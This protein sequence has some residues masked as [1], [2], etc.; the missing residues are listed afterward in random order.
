VNKLLKAGVIAG[1]L[2]VGATLTVD[3]GK[4]TTISRVYIDEAI[5][6][7]V[8][9]FA[10]QYKDG[11]TWKT[12][13]EGKKIGSKFEH[14]FPPVTARHM[15]LQIR[16]ATDGPTIHEFQLFAPSGESE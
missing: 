4:P 14:S 12:V 7:R 2:A 1:T 15:R 5:E 11:G 6:A 3:R 16:D 8:R 13:F 10:L 9:D